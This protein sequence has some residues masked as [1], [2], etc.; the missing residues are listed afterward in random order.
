MN[1]LQSAD[2]GTAVRVRDQSWCVR[3]IDRGHECS[4]WRLEGLER[5]NAG[6]HLV[7]LTPFDI[8]TLV[9]N[10]RF[11]SVRVDAWRRWIERARARA[12]PAHELRGPDEARVR[13]LSHQVEPARAIVE[14]ACTRMLV[15]DGVGLGKTLQ[16][17]LVIKELALRQRLRRALVVVPAGLVDQW[18]AELSAHLDIRATRVDWDLL[19][20]RQHA[21][22]HVHPWT[23]DAVSI[24]SV[25]FLR[26]KEVAGT[27][28]DV[29]WDVLVVDEAHTA[30]GGALRAEA[31]AVVASRSLHVVLLSATPHSGDEARFAALLAL[32]AHEQDADPLVF[33]RTRAPA[34]GRAARRETRLVVR[35]HESVQRLLALLEGY[36]AAVWREQR[37][38]SGR[39]ARLAMLVLRKRAYSSPWALLQSVQQRWSVVAGDGSPEAAQ[40]L[41]PFDAHALVVAPADDQAPDV[42]MAAVRGLS[43][44]RRERAWLGALTQAA[45]TALPHD[46]KLRALVAL[47]RRT[48]EA[49]IVFT[50]YRDTLERAA[51]TLGAVVPIAVVHGGLPREARAAALDAFGRGAARALLA[52]DA[53]AEGLN[54]QRRCRWVVHLEL[55]WN[56]NR[57]E[58]RVGR[59]DRVDQ[60]R[61]VHATCLVLGGSGE[62]ALL[63]RLDQRRARIARALTA[64]THEHALARGALAVDGIRAHPYPPPRDGA[65]ERVAFARVSRRELWRRRRRRGQPEPD[66]VL[67][68]GLYYVAVVPLVMDG[69]VVEEPAVVAHVT[70]GAG[71]WAAPHVIRQ[72]AQEL[73]RAVESELHAA[74]RTHATAR[75]SEVAAWAHRTQPILRARRAAI[76]R[77]L[78]AAHRQWQP[79]LFEGT[80]WDPHGPRSAFAHRREG[81]GPTRGEHADE[82]T[83][84]APR[85][86]AVLAVGP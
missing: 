35:P 80:A 69:T 82:V 7:V 34:V 1:I 18:Q 14:Q 27:L 6:R 36:I 72:R 37:G 28:G 61:P 46:P 30:A 76:E 56:P 39:A 45:R 67:A 3:A 10:R 83:Q 60:P 65:R 9:E 59:V 17:G 58:Q 29:D 38:P 53:A 42:W 77:L 31:V 62:A 41:L 81:G 32:G 16:A 33:R 73:S 26:Q 71:V 48:R 49:A 4:A 52:T 54:L 11:G 20:S 51:R 13:P 19:R 63:E 50:E 2:P 24:V 78:E 57:L 75:A 40:P 23:H 25:D 85:V 5:L 86:I 12:R 21:T 44:R 43:A 79:T 64:S 84:G 15:A 22:P 8:I 68:M 55:P 74:A 70:L 47:L 66:R